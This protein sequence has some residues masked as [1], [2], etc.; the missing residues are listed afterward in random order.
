MGYVGNYVFYRMSLDDSGVLVGSLTDEV[1]HFAGTF[2]N[3]LDVRLREYFLNVPFF[4]DYSGSAF[5]E[6]KVQQ[7]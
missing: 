7:Y 1:R 2:A 5:L 4:E 3:F 6:T